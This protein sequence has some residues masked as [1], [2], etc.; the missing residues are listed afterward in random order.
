MTEAGVGPQV[1]G[2][3]ASMVQK[4][5]GIWVYKGPR[6]CQCGGLALANRQTPILPL[7]HTFLSKDREKME[8]R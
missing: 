7:F 1:T 3:C 5:E 6:Y 2:T 8:G 4:T